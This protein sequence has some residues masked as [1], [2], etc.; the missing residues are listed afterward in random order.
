MDKQALQKK[1]DHSSKELNQLL[2]KNTELDQLH[3]DI[4]RITEKE[5]DSLT[6][7][8]QIFKGTEHATRISQAIHEIETETEYAQKKIQRLIDD[9]E[10]EYYRAKKKYYQLEDDLHFVKNGGVL[11]D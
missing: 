3:E 2:R 1:L 10:E 11:H 5:L 6:E 4:Q 8:A 9:T 7:E